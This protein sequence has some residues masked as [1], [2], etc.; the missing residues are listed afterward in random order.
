MLRVRSLRRSRD[1]VT[2]NVMEGC[3]KY[4]RTFAN[5]WDISGFTPGKMSVIIN[6]WKHLVDD[7]KI[8]ESPSYLHHR[9]KPL[10]AIWGFSVRDE[11]PESDLQELLDFFNGE[12][13]P[14][15]YRATVM[16]GVDHD[17]HQRS[18]WL[19]ETGTGRCDQSLGCW[20]VQR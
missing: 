2:A 1:T 16:L 7:L 10:V 3:E 19:D 17:F 9:G 12:S 18:N 4:G 14:E 11:F 13:T 20:Q 5:M 6:D 8:T 15:K